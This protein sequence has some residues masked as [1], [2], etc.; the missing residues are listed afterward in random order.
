MPPRRQPTARQA[1]LGAELR[2][3]REAAGL[4]ATEA[5]SLLGVNSV[6]MSQIESGIAGV[7]EERLRRLVAHYA[8]DDEALIAALVVMATERKRGWWEEYRGLLPNA[9]LDLAELEHHAGFRWDVDFLHIPGLLQTEDYARALFSYMN[10]DLVKVEVDRWVEHR[11]RRR[12]IIERPEPTPYATVV[13]EAALRVKVGDRVQ[14]AAQLLQVLELSEAE[15]VTVRVIPF[16]VEG[17]GGAGSAMIYAGG[18]TPVLDTVVRDGPHGTAFVDAEA[19]LQRF[20][21]LFRKVEAV[22]LEPERS[23]AFIHR[24]TKEL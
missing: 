3:L 1:R 21:K 7:S 13:H 24:L 16:D 22:A 19:Q 20:R 9:F 15:H 12:V 18:A 23:R 10:T 14:A 6:Q 8:C 11:M 4:K 17:F 2:K 5:A